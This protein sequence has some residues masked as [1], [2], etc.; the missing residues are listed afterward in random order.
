MVSTIKTTMPNAGY[1]L[2]KGALLTQGHRVQWDRVRASMHRVDTLGVLSRLTLT[3]L[4]FLEA[5]MASPERVRADHG[6][7]N[8]GVA[9]LMLTVRGPNSRSFIS[10]KT[11]NGCGEMSG[12]QSP[13]S[14]TLSCTHWRMKGIWIPATV[15]IYYVAT[16]CSCHGLQIPYIDWEASGHLHEEHSGIVV[17]VTR[18]PLND[19]QMEH[20]NANI[21]PIGTLDRRTAYTTLAE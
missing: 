19:Q 14:S 20:L 3:P 12:W 1:R 7:E 6:V 13:A 4:S 18:S 9:E 17:P 2:V 10:G 16:M 21:D 11:L 5:L 8:F 15:P